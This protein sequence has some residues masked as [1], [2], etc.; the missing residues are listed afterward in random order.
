MGGGGAHAFFSRVAQAAAGRDV[1]E[2]GQ[3]VFGQR[4]ALRIAGPMTLCIRL[5]SPLIWAFNGIAS[6]ILSALGLLDPQIANQTIAKGLGAGAVHAA[7]P[8][9]LGAAGRG[10]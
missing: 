10:R 3:D 7:R 4:I 6:R 1:G 9:R 2:L 5:L 8:P